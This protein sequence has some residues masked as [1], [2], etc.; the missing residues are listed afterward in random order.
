MRKHA[1]KGF[2]L[3]ELMIVVAIIGILAAIAIPNF[4]KY[5]LRAKASE[6]STNVAA[7][8][9]AEES[10]R[11]SERVYQGHSGRYGTVALVPAGCKAG[12]D[13]N[14][15]A[16]TDLVTAAAVD[17]SIDGS[18][19]GCYSVAVSPNGTAA[20]IAA[21]SDVD[22]DGVNRCVVLFRATLDATGKAVEDPPAPPTECTDAPA[23]PNG[24][25]TG[26]PY[27]VPVPANDSVF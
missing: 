21:Y 3:I 23:I 4:L 17:W 22:G 13:K 7:L 14:V 26:T 2:T 9:T 15:W 12:T 16:A 19:Y 20:T 18:T 1:P 11:Q 25:A 5:Q 6:L 8:S 10:L 27:G 24:S